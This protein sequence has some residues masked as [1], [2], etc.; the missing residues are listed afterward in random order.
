MA[1]SKQAKLEAELKAWQ[2]HANSAAVRIRQIESELQTL[3]VPPPPDGMMLNVH[4]KFFTSPHTYDFLIK[5]VPG[6]GYY[7]TG[8]LPENSYF[9]SWTAMLEYFNKDD[10]EWRTQ[11]FPVQKSILVP[12]YGGRKNNSGMVF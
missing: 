5:H 10:V 9:P 11:F 12:G 7:T 1:D 2:E 6:K 8:S 3:V 4:V